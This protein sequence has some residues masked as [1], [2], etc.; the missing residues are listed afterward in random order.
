MTARERARLSLSERLNLAVESLTMS[1]MM[2]IVKAIASRI[3]V[4]MY[5]ALRTSACPIISDPTKAPGMLPMPPKTAA[6]KAFRPGIIPMKTI[7]C[8]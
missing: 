2:R 7:N 3:V 1:T 6:T 8:G 5:P 4:E